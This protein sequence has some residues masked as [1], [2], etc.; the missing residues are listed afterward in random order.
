[1]SFAPIMAVAAGGL[2]VLGS[3]QEG[4][5]RK[6]EALARE[7]ELKR[8]AELGK[9]AADEQQASR[10]RELGQSIGTI[11]ALTAQRGLAINSPSAQAIQLSVD[12]DAR[13]DT[14]RIAFNA[15]QDASNRRMAAA[16]ARQSGN[17]AQMA[18]YI[19]GATSLFK[20]VSTAKSAFG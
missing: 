14:Q 19:K 2:Q 7:A 12:K 6:A 18:G 20:T 8:E 5:A 11:R 13:R 9:I 3:I 15:G 17:A 10:L 4:N 1:M 16:A